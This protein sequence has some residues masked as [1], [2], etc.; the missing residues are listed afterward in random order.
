[1]PIIRPQ[2]Q[3]I[4]HNCATVHEY[5]DEL[6][7]QIRVEVRVFSPDG[8]LL[9]YER[10]R[11]A[12]TELADFGR[13]LIEYL[14]PTDRENENTSTI[15]FFAPWNRSCLGHC[16]SP[17]PCGCTLVL[18]D[19][20]PSD[21]LKLISNIAILLRATARI[22]IVSSIIDENQA[23]IR[24]TVERFA[25]QVDGFIWT[26]RPDRLY[27]SLERTFPLRNDYLRDEVSWSD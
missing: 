18:K 22:F 1:M 5:I 25:A 13:L 26:L 17:Q 12:T 2:F 11:Q 9:A 23:A 3:G 19:L 8:H 21:T 7:P 16:W 15:T 4:I 10:G 20:N 6:V 27:Q 24:R 14:D